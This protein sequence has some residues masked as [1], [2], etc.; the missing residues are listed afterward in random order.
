MESAMQHIRRLLF[1]A[2][3]TV[4]LGAVS[5]SVAYA[6][7]RGGSRGGQ[8]QPQQLNPQPLLQQQLLQ[9]QLAQYQL[10]AQQLAQ[11]SQL[12]QGFL[13]PSLSPINNSQT[14][15][16]QVSGQDTTTLQ[17]F[18]KDPRKRVRRM[19]ARLIGQ[20]GLPLQEDLIGLLTD[21]VSSVRQAARHSLV[22]LAATE[23]KRR[24]SAT[25][26]RNSHRR[27]IDFGPSV[28]AGK[29]AQARA[30]RKWHDWWDGQTL[31]RSETPVASR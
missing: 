13:Q 30:A 5:C 27:R 26:H 25:G 8:S 28:D 14:T 24:T 23:M 1:G 16:G 19:A 29:E 3:V 22:R 6:Q 18:L 21:R 17:R 9:Q 12:Q 31:A 11:Q 4:F 2:A 15:L 10:V 20:R 7:C